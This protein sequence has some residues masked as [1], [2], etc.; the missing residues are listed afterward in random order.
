MRIR[1]NPMFVLLCIVNT[2]V[3]IV[4]IFVLNYRAVNYPVSPTRN[5]IKKMIDK[6]QKWKNTTH[7]I[8]YNGAGRVQEYRNSPPL[9]TTQDVSK[10]HHRIRASYFIIYYF[11]Y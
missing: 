6:E 9:S 3:H 5:E 1:N 7:D 2:F 10:I 8:V 4:G 11:L